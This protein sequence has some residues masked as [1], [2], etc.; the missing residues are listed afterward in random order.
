MK[1]LKYI[2]ELMMEIFENILIIIILKIFLLY[3]I[4]NVP[5]KYIVI[6]VI[7]SNANLFEKPYIAT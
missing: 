3:L 1:I 2:I 5:L 7:N 6:F 4:K